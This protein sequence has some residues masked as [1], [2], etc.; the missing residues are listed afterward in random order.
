[1][2]ASQMIRIRTQQQAP[3]WWLALLNTVWNNFWYSKITVYI[4]III[5]IDDLIMLKLLMSCRRVL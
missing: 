5:F 4:N 1:M 2:F 3:G